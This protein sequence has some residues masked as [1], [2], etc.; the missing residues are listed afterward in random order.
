VRPQSSS[1][2]SRV[3]Y[4]R[5][6]QRLPSLA[7]SS[8][9]TTRRP[10][11]P[12]RAVVARHARSGI[13]PTATEGDLCGAHSTAGVVWPPANAHTHTPAPNTIFRTLAAPP[14]PFHHTPTTQPCLFHTARRCRSAALDMRRGAAPT[15]GP[16][17]A[18]A[19]THA[20]LPRVSVESRGEVAPHRPSVTMCI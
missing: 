11:R 17:L 13:A 16:A 7:A 14:P 5:H 6:S 15:R 1:T 9:T 18:P 10:K 3:S 4:P 20:T 2:K 8:S 12:R 19:P